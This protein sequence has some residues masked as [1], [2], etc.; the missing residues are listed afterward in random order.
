MR[1]APAVV[2][3][4]LGGLAATAVSV[5]PAEAHE[6]AIIWDHRNASLSAD[7]HTLHV[8]DEVCD[9]RAVYVEWRTA[10]GVERNIDD[11]ECDLWRERYESPLPATAFRLCDAGAGCTSWKAA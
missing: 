5:T 2:V 11:V 9:G 10:A 1:T 8:Q 6:R 7:H 3:S 4:T